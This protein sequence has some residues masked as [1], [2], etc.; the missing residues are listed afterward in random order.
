MIPWLLLLV[1]VV[2]GYIAYDAYS[3]RSNYKNVPFSIIAK[4]MGQDTSH[5]SINAQEKMRSWHLV[6]GLGNLDQA[7]FAFFLLFL[8][9]AFGTIFAFLQ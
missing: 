8:M 2:V 5:V 3:L 4:E 1:T 6:W 7:P 9:F